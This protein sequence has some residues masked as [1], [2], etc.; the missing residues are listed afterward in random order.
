MCEL[1]A[2]VDFNARNLTPPAEGIP[3]SAEARQ[4]GLQELARDMRVFDWEDEAAVRDR[5]AMLVNVT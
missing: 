5:Y 2:G 3:L 1:L 4:Q